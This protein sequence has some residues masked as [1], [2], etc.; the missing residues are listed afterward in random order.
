[1]ISRFA[2]VVTHS[3]KAYQRMLSK[4]PMCTHSITSA[5]LFLVGDLIAQRIERPK[6]DITETAKA[7]YYASLPAQYDAASCWNFD[8]TLRLLMF[9]ATMSGPVA[10]CWFRF[11]DRLFPAHSI[12]AIFKKIITHTFAYAPAH[13]ACF[14]AWM[15]FSDGSFSYKYGLSAKTL[16][17]RKQLAI[18]RAKEKT[19]PLWL[20]GCS[21]W[22][23]VV[24]INYA[25]TP[26]EKR[27]LVNNSCNLVWTCF[28]SYQTHKKNTPQ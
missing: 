1:M 15:G 11:M 5:T 9:G 28:L 6:C 8:R 24:L 18:L 20:A 25:F 27:V 19:I 13:L 3:W 21:F 14:C 10:V 26:L 2:S 4:R 22:I 7:D 16:E 12:R 17:E 23:P